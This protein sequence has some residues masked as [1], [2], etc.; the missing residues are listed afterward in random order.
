L[1]VMPNRR[2]IGPS[3]SNCPMSQIVGIADSN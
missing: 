2:A 1:N 3:A